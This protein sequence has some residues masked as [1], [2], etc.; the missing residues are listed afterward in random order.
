MNNLIYEQT[1]IALSNNDNNLLWL[2]TDKS[3]EEPGRR[4]GTLLHVEEAYLLK[5]SA[6]M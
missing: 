6:S 1:L 5:M 2:M 3:G 4:Q